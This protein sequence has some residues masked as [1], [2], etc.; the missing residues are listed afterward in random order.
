V[1]ER[2]ITELLPFLSLLILCGWVLVSHFRANAAA[3]SRDRLRETV[4]DLRKIEAAHRRL[5]EEMEVEEG[6]GFG[7]ER[8]RDIHMQV[9]N[10]MAADAARV[11]PQQGSKEREHG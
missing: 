5:C 1:S 6:F 7:S 11:H 8:D 4:A 10:P 2:I 3:D 9:H